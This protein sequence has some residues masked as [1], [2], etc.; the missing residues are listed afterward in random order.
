M[1]MV[2]EMAIQCC[3]LDMTYM[4][5]G[6]GDRLKGPLEGSLSTREQT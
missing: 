2:K 4:K 1:R 5:C 3:P 6:D